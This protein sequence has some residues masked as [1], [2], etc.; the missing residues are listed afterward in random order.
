M[1]R[2]RMSDGVHQEIVEET[3]RHCILAAS[4]CLDERSRAW[5]NKQKWAR[6]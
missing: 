6:R 2:S 1:T 5:P 3:W 4:L